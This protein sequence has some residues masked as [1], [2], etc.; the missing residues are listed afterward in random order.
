MCLVLRQRC[1]F[2]SGVPVQGA[3][4]APDPI[5]AALSRHDS[6][7]REPR[8]RH[9]HV[10]AGLKFE[11]FNFCQLCLP[12]QTRWNFTQYDMDALLTVLVRQN[13]PRNWC[14]HRRARPPGELS[15]RGE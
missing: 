2:L 14:A 15:Y 12:R 1:L 11:S 13:W 3:G 8:G 9:C 10:I 6:C 7:E 5:K 4:D